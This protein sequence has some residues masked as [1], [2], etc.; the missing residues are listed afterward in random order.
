MRFYTIGHSSRSLADFLALLAANGIE[1]VADVRRFPHSHTHPQYDL[2]NLPASLQTQ[3]I[4]YRHLPALG[5]RRPT[6]LA[7]SPNGGWQERTFRNYADYMMG[8]A[9]AGGI[10]EL[11]VLAKGKRLAY[12]C[13]EAVPWRCHRRLI[14]DY[15]VAQGHEV[16]DIISPAPPRPHRLTP[17][18]VKTGAYLTYPA[19]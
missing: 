16:Y 3:G 8:A 10:A 11:L 13:A 1:T 9:F 2:A 14:S 15:L 7:A 6:R 4:Y 12:L 5:G 17:F 19:V 18:A